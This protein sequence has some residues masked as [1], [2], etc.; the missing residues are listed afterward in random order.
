MQ[1]QNAHKGGMTNSENDSLKKLKI[2]ILKICQ[3]CNSN[4]FKHLQTSSNIF[5]HL[6]TSS[7][8]F[9]HL[10]TSSNIFKQL[11]KL[12]VI[13][14]R[15]RPQTKEQQ[16]LELAPRSVAALHSNLQS[17]GKGALL[18]F[19]LYPFIVMC[20]SIATDLRSDLIRDELRS[21]SW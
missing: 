10:Q 5:K 8:I 7:H 11:W 14:E 16:L 17:N 9:K 13:H 19:L 4:I 6:Q 1:R 12:H 3:N 2:D 21:L 15:L 18:L 20:L